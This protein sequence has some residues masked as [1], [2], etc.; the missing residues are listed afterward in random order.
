VGRAVCSA[1]QQNCIPGQLGISSAGVSGTISDYYKWDWNKD[2]VQ[3]KVSAGF[4]TIGSCGQVFQTIVDITGP[5]I[6]AP[7]RFY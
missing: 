1:G 7:S 4:N 2:F 6:P 3:A 5:L